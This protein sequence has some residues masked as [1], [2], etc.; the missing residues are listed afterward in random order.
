MV[1]SQ[2][3]CLKHNRTVFLFPQRFEPFMAL[4]RNTYIGNGWSDELVRGVVRLYTFLHGF[5]PLTKTRNVFNWIG[6]SEEEFF[7]RSLKM[8]TEKGYRLEK[9]RGIPPALEDLMKTIC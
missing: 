7:D 3:L 8:A 2:E 6:Y 1:L 9:K 5:I 4:E